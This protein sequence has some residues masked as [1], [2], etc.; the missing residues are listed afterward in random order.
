[1]QYVY[2]ND[3]LIEA[4][5][6]ILSI[7]NRGFFYGD[8]FF[9]S[10][11][12]FNKKPFN[13]ESHYQRIK[14]SLQLLSL[15]FNLDKD[16]MVMNIQ[17]LLEKNNI[18]NNGYVKLVF[19]RESNGKYLSNSNKCSILMIANQLEEDKFILNHIGL[20]VTWYNQ[21]YKSKTSISNIKTLNALISV[22]AANFARDNNYNDA[23][24][25]N[26][27]NVP[28][29]TTSS[30]LFIV[31]ENIIYTSKLS[32]GCVSGS[33]RQLIMSFN[34]DIKEVI[35]DKQSISCAD[36]VFLSNAMG[37]KWVKKIQEHRF[38]Q[39]SYST[40]FVNKLNDLI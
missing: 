30:N 40:Y 15:D 11:R 6:V 12:F 21:E 27:D 2:L 16:S 31:K 26:T 36:E 35:L 24:I 20:N 4:Q 17:E 33:M 10:I 32:E 8:G 38:D 23:I 3:K 9:E 29:E 14:T 37:I 28:I 18:T 39:K 34:Q 19:F 22:L 25:F 13:F 7:N 1:M 5:Q